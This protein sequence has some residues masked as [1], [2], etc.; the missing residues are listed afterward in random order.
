M[1]QGVLLAAGLSQ[2]LIPVSLSIP[3]CLMPVGWSSKRAGV[4]L[5][6]ERLIDQMRLCGIEHIVV[7][8]NHLKDTLMNFLGDGHRFDVVFTYLYQER[9]RGEAD[10]LYLARHL[11]DDTFVVADADNYI[12]TPDVFVRLLARHQECGAQATVGVSRVAD[13][14]QYAI[15]KL[16][17]KLRA[18]Q[19]V[20]KPESIAYWDN[21]AKTGLYVISPEVLD[22]DLHH[23]LSA[24]GEYSTTELFNYLIEHEHAIVACEVFETFYAD[25][26]SW[27]GYYQVCQRGLSH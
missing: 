15:V 17:D 4:E 16:D 25:I 27:A 10:G 23:C 12:E 13:A 22:I 8:V 18:E 11:L 24:A 6:V 1:T 9:L 21:M 14:R 5:L 2:R 20:E 26:G 3:K 7:V 19:I